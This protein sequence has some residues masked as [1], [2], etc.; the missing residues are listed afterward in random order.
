MK[1]KPY[2]LT[3][4]ICT[5][6]AVVSAV[7]FMIS[8][9][10]KEKSTRAVM[11]FP[12]FESGKVYAEERFIPKETA[13]GTERFFVD[14]LLLGPLT[15]SFKKLFPGE[16]SVEFFTIDSSGTAYI[17]LSKD[18]LKT[19]DDAADI[20]IGISLLKRNIVKNFT[21][22]NTVLVYIDGKSV[23]EKS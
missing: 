14:D 19:S 22:I 21:K 12:S 16:T 1:N 4:V 3:A 13:Q 7:I 11:Y 17:G 20:N 10:K 2:Y 23:Y 18:A 5:V 15:N 9:Q 6:L 8:I